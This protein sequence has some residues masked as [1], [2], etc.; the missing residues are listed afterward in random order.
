MDREFGGDDVRNTKPWFKPENRARALEFLDCVRPI[1][2]GH[3]KT[4]AQV[5]VNWVL[6]QPGVT[7][8]IVGARRAQQVEENVGGTGWALADDDLAA[9]RERLEELGAP[10]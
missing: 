8:A 1:A 6:C 2:A 9:I 7:A 4:L 3:G 10:A 5:A